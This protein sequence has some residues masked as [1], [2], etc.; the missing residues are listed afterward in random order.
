MRTFITLII[1]I[2]IVIITYWFQ[3]GIKQ[4]F[5]TAPEISSH[6]PDYF[7]ENFTITRMNAQGL[8]QY[9]LR[10]KKMLHYDDDG[11]AEI[12]QPF[13]TFNQVG[14]TI[15][16][17][18]KRAQYLKDK[19]VIYLHEDVI[20]F[21]TTKPEKNELSIHTDYLKINTQSR[22]AETDQIAKITTHFAKFNT[23]GLVF[24][25]LQGSFKLMSQVKGIYEKPR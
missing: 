19:N 15:T 23:V 24:D 6:F 18:A 10:A 12:E 4:Q 21:R 2:T 16:V 22:M 8:P 17:Q 11:S 25:G 9:T 3:M 13:L 1:V 14:S 5:E 7:M 20:V